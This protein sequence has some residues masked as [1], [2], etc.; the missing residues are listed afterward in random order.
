MSRIDASSPV[1]QVR[2]LSIEFPTQQRHV[3]VKAVNGVSFDVYAGETFG[4]IGESG[5]GKTT[6]GRALVSLIPPTRGELLQGGVQPSSLSKKALREH[7]RD[8]QILFQDPNAALNPRMR[9][10]DSVM[11]PLE[12]AGHRDQQ[13]NRAAALQAMARVGLPTEFAERYPH[14]LSGGQKQRV[15]IARALTLKPRLIVCDEVVAALDVSIRG[16]VLNLFADLQRE[17]GLTYVFITHDLSVVSHIS[18]RIAVMYLGSLMELG[19]SQALSEA[20]L[21]PYTQALLSA[22]PIPIPRSM[23]DSQRIHLQG[24]VPSPMNPPSGC[25]FRTRCPKAI[26]ACAQSRPVL[27]EHV[28]GHW[29]ACHLAGH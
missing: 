4:V 29:V 2:D 5:S 10:V 3:T 21:H 13:A 19:P 20:P 26:E 8:F 28:P 9:I 25:P 16:E 18:D 7:R 17:F 12:V 14:Q 15:I 6:L 11:E 22:E 27:T 1:L 24:E 23:R